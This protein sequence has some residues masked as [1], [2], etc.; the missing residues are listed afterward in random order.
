MNVSDLGL[1]D[2]YYLPWLPGN[3]IFS[4]YVLYHRKKICNGLFF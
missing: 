2:R 1:A 4:I 3:L